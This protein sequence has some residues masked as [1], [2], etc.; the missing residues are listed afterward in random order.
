MPPNLAD[1]AQPREGDS[2]ASTEARHPPASGVAGPQLSVDSVTGYGEPARPYRPKCLR[3][4]ALRR[5]RPIV[6]LIGI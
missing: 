3:H 1:Y 6:V 5:I 4:N 2:S